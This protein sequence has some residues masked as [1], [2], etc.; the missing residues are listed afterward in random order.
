MD[1]STPTQPAFTQLSSKALLVK[2]TIRRANLVRRD[3]QVTHSIQ[4]QFA[5][6][7]LAAFTKLF[8]SK[9]SPIHEIMRC[10]NE[11][12][13]YHREQT[14]PYVDSGPR[15]LPSANYM[16]YT[17]EMKSKIAHVEAM[18]KQWM[19]QYAQL[20]L[21]DIVYRNGG[22]M[23]GRASSNDYPTAEQF[24][25]RMSFDLR[26]M[27]MPDQRHFLFDL[28]EDDEKAF[29]RAME[30]VEALARN[31]TLSRML[32]PVSRLTKRL[33]DY[34]GAKGERFHTSGLENIIEGCRMARKLAIDPPSELLTQ[35]NELEQMCTT[36]VLGVDTL[37]ESQAARDTARQRL[38]EVADKM[39]AMYG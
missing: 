13:T 22:R 34:T 37:K 10:A 33:S 5:D 17:Q 16:E 24:E 9:S 11:V 19:P 6:Q 26:F 28:S 15:L 18:L 12:Y 35:I 23:T 20:V 1:M 32:E 30:E 25:Q 27:P 2:L 3:Q 4:Q 21:D 7:S 14:L 38:K 39:G 36:Y 29:T 31:D 8:T